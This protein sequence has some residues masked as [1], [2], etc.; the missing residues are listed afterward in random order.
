MKRFWTARKRLQR[1]LLRR[2]RAGEHLER[3][4]R[5]RRPEASRPGHLGARTE[6]GLR[7]ASPDSPPRAS[8]DPP[9]LLAERLDVTPPGA[10]SI[11]TP[12]PTTR[13]RPPSCHRF[14]RSVELQ[15]LARQLEV[16][17]LRHVQKRHSPNRRDQRLRH[18]RRRSPLTSLVRHPDWEALEPRQ[19][20]PGV[21]PNRV[22]VRARRGRPPRA[23]RSTAARRRE[24]RRPPLGRARP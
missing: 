11:R 22:V 7:P 3:L 16:E 19:G 15:A 13:C 18:G 4:G 6:I 1:D 8:G 9:C 5:E 14:A 17:R 2:D 10:A 24:R 20:R 23:S 12:A 21:G